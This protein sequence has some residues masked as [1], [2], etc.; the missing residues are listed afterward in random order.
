MWD[1]AIKHAV[2]IKNRVLTAALP[3]GDKDINVATS[4]TLYK[5]FTG[6]YPDF[7]KLR[8]FGCKA[9]PYKIN[10]DY[11]TTFKP[12]IRDKTQIFIKIEGN[13]IWKVLNVKTLAIAKTT[14]ARFN[15]YSFP[16]ITSKKI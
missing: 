2:Q 9:V 10:V 12:Q 5:A 15:E 4:I 1:Y 13:S 3:F 7:D 14:N 8:V 11:L 16:L 6:N